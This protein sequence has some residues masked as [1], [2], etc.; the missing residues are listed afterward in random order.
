MVNEV[1]FCVFQVRTVEPPEVIEFGDAVSV[2]AGVGV[3]GLTVTVAAQCTV[4]PVP[5]AVMV[6]VVVPEGATVREPP[7]ETPPIP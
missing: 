7:V 6:Y 3:G 5:E 2:H 4:P 1:T